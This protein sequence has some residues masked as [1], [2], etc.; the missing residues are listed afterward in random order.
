M[1]GKKST[2]DVRGGQN[3]VNPLAE[4]ALADRAKEAAGIQKR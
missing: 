1:F 3:Q 4:S 2:G